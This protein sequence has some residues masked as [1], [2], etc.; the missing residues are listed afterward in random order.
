MWKLAL[1]YS[2]PSDRVKLDVAR[3]ILDQQFISKD[4][5]WENLLLRLRRAM[6]VTGD[7]EL[8]IVNRIIGR[9]ASS[10]CR[11]LA[12][13]YQRNFHDS[14]KSL[15][16]LNDL[17]VSCRAAQ[18][19]ILDAEAKTLVQGLNGRDPSLENLKSLSI[20]DNKINSTTCFSSSSFP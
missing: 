19:P 13:V 8:D 17:I 15:T 14:A 12:A 16:E 9:W 4:S 1:E 20:K 7:K 10:K 18:E 11:V 2:E 6:E 5:D 3:V